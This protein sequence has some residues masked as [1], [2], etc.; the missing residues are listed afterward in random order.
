MSRYNKQLLEWHSRQE[1]KKM[2]F[3]LTEADIE[4][5]N[6]NRPG[7]GPHK[8]KSIQNSSKAYMS[9][10]DLRKYEALPPITSDKKGC[11]EA[12]VSETDPQ[13]QP[14]DCFTVHLGITARTYTIPEFYSNFIDSVGTYFIQRYT[15]ISM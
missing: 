14:P 6:P 3:T 4:P 9:E 13:P 11:S 10:S 2:L 8:L 12:D 1:E 15:N 7:S 5:K